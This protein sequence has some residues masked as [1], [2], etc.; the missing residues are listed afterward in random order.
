MDNPAFIIFAAVSPMLI[1]F[2]KQ[3]GFSRQVNALIALACYIVVG[4]VGVVVSGEPLTVEN[5]VP[6]IA[7]ATVV[8]SAAY[9]LVWTNIGANEV[10]DNSIEERVLNATSVV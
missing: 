5:A 8:G 6:L 10:G 3:R 4:V 1:A 2:I 7:L 9:Q